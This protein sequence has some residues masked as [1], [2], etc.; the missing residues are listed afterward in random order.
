ML[1]PH[2]GSPGFT[3]PKRFVSRSLRTKPIS[4]LSLRV[5]DASVPAKP[6]LTHGGPFFYIS[7]VSGPVSDLADPK[8]VQRRHHPSSSLAYN[9]SQLTKSKQKKV[10]KPL[11]L[12]PQ[13]P[14][15]KLFGFF[16]V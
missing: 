14:T 4:Y 12:D 13:Y 3:S 5:P 11:N 6:L 10:V 8:D 16:M 1:E 15:F 9:L 7:G 2:H